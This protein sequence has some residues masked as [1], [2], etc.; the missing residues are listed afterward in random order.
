VSEHRTPCPRGA[1]RVAAT[2]SIQGLE[3]A[4]VELVDLT[5]ERHPDRVALRFGD[6]DTSVA[7]TDDVLLVWALI[8][9]ADR[10][11][12]HLVAHRRPR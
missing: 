9:E 7:L 1:L 2:T 4:R 3:G 5:S 12:A 8:V 10:Q 6:S 11:L